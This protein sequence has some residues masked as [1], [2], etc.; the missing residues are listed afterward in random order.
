MA[1]D[2]IEVE[3]TQM[4]DADVV[5]PEAEEDT[6]DV[7]DA[8]KG[9]Y[10]ALTSAEDGV[11]RLSGMYKNWFLDYA[12]YVIL[13]RAVPHLADGL[14]PVQRRILHAMKCV[15]DGRY[16]KVANVVGQAM[17][18]HPHGDASIKDAL[19]QLGQKGLLIDMQGNWGNILTGDEAAAG[20]YIEARLSKFALDVV[21]NKKTTE[22]ML[23]Y[24]GRK[25]EPVTLPIKFPLL[26]AQGADGIAVGL[27]S[28]ILPHNFV[29]LIN[30][31]I[32]YLRG[33][34]FMLVPDF[35]T[36]GI[37]DASNYNDGLRGGS[38][39]VRARISKI[40]KRTLAITE[41]PYGTTS[42]SIKESIIKANDKGKIKI[43][44]V[45]D[46]TAEKVEIVIQ[47][48]ADESS[49]KTIDALYAFTDC[50]VSISPNACVIVD[51]KPVFM[52]VSD[53]LRHS[54]EHTKALL[55]K[56]LEI[57]LHEL[58][59]AWHAA[60]LE[61][62]FIE[63]KLYQL[64]E[65]C[66]TR[67]AAYEA[68]DKGLE[69]F[70]AKLRRE[71][72]LEDVQRLTELKFIRISRYDS[73][74]ADNEIKQIEKDIKQTQHDLDHLTDYAVAY[75]ERI[76]SKYSEGKERRTEIREFDT[77]EAW[78]VASSNAKLYVD[79]AEGFFGFGKSMKDS[80]FVCDCSNL[81]DVIIILKDGR[82]K[83]TKISEKAFF[84]KG[85][86]YIG[87]YKRNDE[88]TIYNMLYR[89]G[90]GGAIMM[91]RCAIKSVTRDKEYD[92][93]KGTAKSELLYLSVN[94]NGEAEILKIYLR[95]RARLKKCIIDL[96]LSTLAI[97]GRQSVGN[98]VTRYPINKIVLKERCAST[99]GGQNIWYDEDVRRLNTDGR[100]LLLGEFKGEDKLVVWTAKN[101]YYIT[102][103]DVQ[104]HFP[105]DTIRVERYISSRVYAVC[106]YDGEQNY[107]YM[108]RFQ[109]EEG[110][111]TQFFLEEGAPMRFESM[112]YRKG[113][114]LE[115]TF[116]GQH[117]Q[118]PTE[119]VDVDEFI[120]IKSHRAKGKRLTTYE[121]A[122]LRFI[123]PEEPEMEEDELDDEALMDD[124][125]MEGA[126][127]TLDMDDIV[128]EDITAD[129][130]V[131][132]NER[133]E[134]VDALGGSQLNLF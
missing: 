57:K 14:K 47:V 34:E 118:R 71:V 110:D 84:D 111:K 9:K 65:G 69:P 54:T 42:E 41:I 104:Q 83:I 123:E 87:I 35:Q 12:S 91:K 79:R 10:G 113:A 40:D 31:S 29:E 68:V 107:Y 8:P 116:G 103:F 92:L 38:V 56:E 89:D 115:I 25:E 66:R 129:P 45:D 128:G 28:K 72:T 51:N 108:K 30:A 109:L 49:D 76:K 134:A 86:Y 106:Y 82:Y 70:K 105:D 5:V 20:R 58:N 95:P 27:A 99:L 46:N 130:N 112:T 94:P 132:Y 101:Q 4:E 1:K 119:M 13:E 75:F 114:Q 19:V 36:G 124:D 78:K 61:R 77:I 32:A 127:E 3:D 93:T 96:D 88:R 23:A 24:D 64:I 80:E 22:W 50:E 125:T 17:Q 121:V 90:R 67:E 15:E 74:K 7:A 100:G 37:M 122:T 39:R 81:D 33:E 16:N 85:I 26:L 117:E 60:S 63:N 126:D 120:A 102:N 59:E 48:A 2:K 52:G 6:E 73:D 98:L 97:K 11:R 44:K 133:A 21:F 53:I 43:K 131:N 18:Y 55:G 62:I